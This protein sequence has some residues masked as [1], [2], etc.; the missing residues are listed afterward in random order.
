MTVEAKQAYLRRLPLIEPLFAILKNRLGDQ[1]LSL[2]GLINV[3]A[4]WSLLD[5]AFNLRTLWPVW[6][7]RLDTR[8]SA[9]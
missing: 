7:A 2:R 8:L 6:R 9:V 4:D 3:K 1:R 5:T